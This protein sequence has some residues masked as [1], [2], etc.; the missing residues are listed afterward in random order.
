MRRKALVMTMALKI[1]AAPTESRR[2]EMAKMA[3][4]PI[5]MDENVNC[6][7]RKDCIARVSQK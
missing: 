4:R 2:V 1:K 6:V 7:V 5:G 3:H